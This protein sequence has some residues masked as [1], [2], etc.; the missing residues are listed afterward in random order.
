MGKGAKVPKG[1][2][3]RA[4]ISAN[5]K[6]RFS[7]TGKQKLNGHERGETLQDRRGYVF[8]GPNKIKLLEKQLHRRLSPVK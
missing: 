7:R 5:G 4:R 2:G 6:V 3:K 1:I 8:V